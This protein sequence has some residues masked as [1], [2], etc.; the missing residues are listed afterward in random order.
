LDFFKKRD[1]R[2]TFFIIGSH[3][4]D[5]YHVALLKRLVDEGHEL[6]N[7]TFTHPLGFSKLSIERKEQ[8]IEKC[9]R[10]IKN[11]TGILPVGFRAPGWDVDS[12]TIRILEERGY[13]YDSSI[14]PSY[15]NLI[16]ILRMVVSSRNLGLVKSMGKLMHSLAPLAPYR[17][18]PNRIYVRGNSKI[19]EIPANATPFFR[20]P[21]YG[22]FLFG[23]KSK[24]VF[25]YSLKKIYGSG[26][27]LNYVLHSVEL[28]DQDKD[29]V[30]ERIMRLCHPA[31]S[32]PFRNKM[33]LY[34]YLFEELCKYYRFVPLRKLHIKLFW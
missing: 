13:K 33:E 9:E 25:L 19:M 6:G 30:D 18:N 34:E 22:T 20:I 26:I 12:E 27:P 8:E 3:I 21:F 15:F 16:T 4:K 10:V 23:T 29:L 24:K 31:F 1:I 5:E 11:A 7:H 2:V 17:P 14:Y 32:E 28:Y